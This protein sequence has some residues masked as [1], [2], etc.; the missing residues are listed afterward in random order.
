MGNEPPLAAG[1]LT[2]AA[3]AQ[4]YDVSISTLRHAL[5]R[6]ALPGRKLG[7]DWIVHLDDV[8]AYMTGPRQGRSRWLTEEGDWT[9]KPE[10]GSDG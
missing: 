8:R 9:A 2:L 1:W 3:A 6:G 4:H 7:R 5:Q 10:E